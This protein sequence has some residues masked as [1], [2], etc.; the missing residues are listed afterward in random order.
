VTADCRNYASDEPTGHRGVVSANGKGNRVVSDG[1]PSEPTGAGQFQSNGW[2]WKSQSRSVDSG[3][4]I[5]YHS[6]TLCTRHDQERV[7]ESVA[8]SPTS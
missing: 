7:I 3:I 8:E 4:T 1:R 5:D 2:I 6:L